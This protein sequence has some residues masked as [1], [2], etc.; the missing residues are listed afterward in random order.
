MGD[1]GVVG[2]FGDVV[3]DGVGLVEDR[4]DEFG[5]SSILMTI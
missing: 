5:D 1:G 4:V 3:D 2:D